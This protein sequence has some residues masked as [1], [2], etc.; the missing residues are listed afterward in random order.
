MDDLICALALKKIKGLQ[1]KHIIFLLNAFGKPCEIFNADKSDLIKSGLKMEY[2]KIL[3][4]SRIIRTAF[5]DAI[6]EIEEASKNGVKI[7]TF[8]SPL[9]PANLRNIKNKP[10]ILYYKGFLKENLKSAAAVI[11]Q[12]KP[13]EYA[14][15][16]AE[17]ITAQLCSYGYAIISGLALGIDSAAHNAALKKNGYTAAYIGSGLLAP[18]YPPENRDLY[19][20]IL[21]NGGAVVS[22]LPLY[23]SISSKNLVARDRLQSGSGLGTFALSSPVKSGTMKTCRFSVKQKRP[24][25]IPEYNMNLMN[26]YDNEGLKSLY[27]EL[28]IFGIKL[29]KDFSADI[30]AAVEEM[31]NIHNKLYADKF[32]E[33][34]LLVQPG[35]FDFI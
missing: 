14:V 4:N 35:L 24:V 28:G 11:G 6:K 26:S 1:N 9:Y 23:E 12:R 5:F 21:L 29:N 19:N 22:E 17:D 3:I 20:E 10:L 25:F 32:D 33:D 31:K 2:I 16:L 27:G 30:G 8:N 34:D 7:I 13:P 15:K 18:V